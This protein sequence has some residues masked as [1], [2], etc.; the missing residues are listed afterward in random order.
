MSNIDWYQ[1][2]DP[3]FEAKQT[4]SEDDEAGPGHCEDAGRVVEH[5]D[6]EQ[7]GHHDV[8]HPDE[9]YYHRA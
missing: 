5:G 7:V 9:A 3:V 4:H 2:R 6:L 1:T 8:Q